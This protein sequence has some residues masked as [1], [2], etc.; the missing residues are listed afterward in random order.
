MSTE[1]TTTVLMTKDEAREC[2]NAIIRCLNDARELVLDLYEREGWRAL[3]YASW[4]ECVT[5]EFPQYSQSYLY[6]QLEA[7]SCS[8]SVQSV[9]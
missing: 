2:V 8:L 7:G 9:S 4:R 3:G 5:A 6:R 1:V